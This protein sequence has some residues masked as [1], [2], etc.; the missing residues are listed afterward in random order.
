MPAHL[1]S[2]LILAAVPLLAACEYEGAAY[3][4]EGKDHSISLVREQRWF[5]SSEVEQAVV[6]SRMPTCMRRHDIKPG[7]RR[8]NSHCSS[9]TTGT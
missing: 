8:K 3:L 7:G 2:L 6:V 9:G 4:I 5:W 1:K